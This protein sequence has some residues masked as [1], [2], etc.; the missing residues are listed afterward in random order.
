MQT[1]LNAARRFDMRL[2]VVAALI[3]AFAHGAADARSMSAKDKKMLESLTPE[4]RQ[5]VMAR[6]GPE[7]TVEGV[8]ETMIL[9]RLSYIHSG[10]TIYDVDVEQGMARV[11]FADGRTEVVPVERATLTP[12]AKV[13]PQPK[14]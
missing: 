12:V 5:E 6:V 13:V 11:T 3:A 7:Q 2:F 4:L 9:N 1:I 10:A 8:L 14:Q